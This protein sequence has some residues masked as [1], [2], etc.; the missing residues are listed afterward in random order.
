[1]RTYV[2][3]LVAA[4]MWFTYASADAQGAEVTMANPNDILFSLPT[5]NDSL[6]TVVQGGDVG[7]HPLSMH[8][9]DW[10]QFELIS[11]SLRP[12]IEAEIAD[13]QRIHTEHA[14][15]LKGDLTAYRKCHLRKRITSPI[16]ADIQLADLLAPIAGA[17]S[18][19]SITL[20]QDPSPVVSGY[21]VQASNLLV[22]G[23][24]KDGQVHSIALGLAGQPALS[25]EAAAALARFAVKN[26]LIL[27]HWP[28]AR[29]TDS[30]KSITTA[31]SAGPA[32]QPSK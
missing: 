18:F 15:A 13:I 14:V 16:A 21:A 32:T 31:L 2:R 4:V 1:M 3:L 27:V 29:F 7:A 24:Q 8:E 22:Y 20:G 28:S 17:K 6:P 10:R 19:T 23:Q 12:Q 9:D 26:H 5:I 11:Q 30:E 25:P